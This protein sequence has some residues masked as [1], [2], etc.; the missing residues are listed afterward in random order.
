MT[1]DPTN[2]H[3]DYERPAPD[4]IDEWS[5]EQLQAYKD[6]KEVEHEQEAQERKAELSREQRDTLAQL[7]KATNNDGDIPTEQVD[8]GDA[9][10]TVKA[11]MTGTMEQRF[12]TIADAETPGDVSGILIDAV[13]DLIV[14]DEEPDGEAYD[15][16][17]RATWEAYYAKHGSEGLMQIFEVVSDPAMTRREN[18]KFRGQE[19]DGN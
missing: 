14:D 13:T 6:A 10:V 3:P 11:K 5:D 4:N 12:D 16:T 19:R 7:E 8:I 15:F 9:T 18:L 1:T 17:D 2:V